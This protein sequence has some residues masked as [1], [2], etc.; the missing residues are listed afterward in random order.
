MQDPGALTA[1]HS[2]RASFGLFDSLAG[3]ELSPN[4]TP[5]RNPPLHPVPSIE[6]FHHHNHH[7]FLHHP[8]Y[9][10]NPSNP[11]TQYP[12]HTIADP[13]GLEATEAELKTLQRR[14]RGL[15]IELERTK[16]QRLLGIP[17]PDLQERTRFREQKFCTLNRAGNAL[18]AWHDSRRERRLYPPRMA[19]YRTLNCG[20][21]YSEAL[22]EESLSRNGVGSFWPGEHVRMDPSLRNCL[23]KLLQRV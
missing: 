11:S 23:L 16:S 3:H 13:Q 5:R 19:P 7:H 15:E 14:L 12:P 17:P 10:S 8:S 6:D 22:F 4:M 20:C 9:P 1:G 2:S 18:C 21:T